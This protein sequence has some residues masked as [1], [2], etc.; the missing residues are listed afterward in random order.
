M[1]RIKKA[2]TDERFDVNKNAMEGIEEALYWHTIGIV[3]GSH[4][5]TGIAIR[6]NKH[7]VF[8]TAKHVI[9]EAAD[10]ELG[11]FFRPSGTLKRTDWWQSHSPAGRIAPALST[12]ILDRFQHPNLDLA[13]LIV[14]PLLGKSVN[15]RFFDL[16]VSARLPREVSSVAAIGFPA[17]SRQQLLGGGNAVAAAPIWGNIE[18][19]KHW[20]PD[21]YKPR[22]HLLLHFL[23][24]T[25]G[26]HPG[27]FSGA[28]VW[29]HVATPK[30]GLWTPN[31]ALTGLV[32]NYYPRKQMLLI[33]RV[34]KLVTFLRR[35]CPAPAPVG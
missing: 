3:T 35:V 20:R 23:P 22:S 9:D 13:C 31:L 32:T 25:V 6:F 16:P 26:K 28:G 7:S 19:G 24:A 5:G 18:K 21:D 1:S 30:P 15:V 27:G 34:E 29:H 4:I 14:S 12:D 8:L 2:R 10:D 17:D 11:F 33:L